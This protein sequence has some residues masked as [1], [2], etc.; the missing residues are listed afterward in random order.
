MIS[1]PEKLDDTSMALSGELALPR[2]LDAE[3]SRR[4]SNLLHDPPSISEQETPSHSLGVLT[5]EALFEQVARDR[6]QEAFSLLYDRYSPRVYALLLH[7]MRTEEDAQDVLQEVFA[8][9]WQKSPMYFESRGNVAAWVLS[10]ARNRAVDELRSKRYKL[11]GMETSLVISDDRPEL[12]RIIAETTLPDMGLHTADQQ[13]E[14]RSALLDLSHD[15]RAVIDLAYFGGLTHLE[16]SEKLQMPI[17]TVKTKIR[18]AVLK[19]GKTL[20]PHF[21]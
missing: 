20:K 3:L 21:G 16:I 14:V 11:R 13:R 18:Q 4:I 2:E 9:V 15:H 8:Q 1:V 6:S 5:D 12:E 7:M 17:G 10:L 19:L